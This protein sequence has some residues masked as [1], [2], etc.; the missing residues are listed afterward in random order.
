I[1]YSNIDKPG[2][3]ED[4]C[5]RPQEHFRPEIES[6]LYIAW[7]NPAAADWDINTKC[8]VLW[9]HD[10]DAGDSLT[11]QRARAFDAIVVLSQ[12][13]K[14][15]FLQK[16]PFVSPDKIFVIGNGVDFSRFPVKANADKEPHRVMY[17]SSPDRGLDIILEHIW[18][19]VI[20]EVPDAELHVYYG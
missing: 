20:K 13:H 17:S 12:W 2:Y 4:A 15:Y 19:K 6:D 11:P 7:R 5:Y 1:V 16:Y 18:P 10:T 9:M 3:Y 14:S 8:L